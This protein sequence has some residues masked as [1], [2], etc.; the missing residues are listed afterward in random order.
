MKSVHDNGG[1]IGRVNADFAATDS[2][3]SGSQNKKNSGVWSLDAIYLNA[4]LTVSE[5]RYIKWNI[6]N[7]N[8]SSD[9]VQVSDFYIVS[10]GSAVSW[11]SPTVTLTGCAASSPQNAYKLFDSNTSTKFYSY[12]YNTTGRV[13]T[14][15]ADA[16][17]G[18]SYNLDS[19]Y[20]VTGNDS[21]GRDPITWTFE[22]S[23]DGTNY[24]VLDTVTN[25]TITT[26]R[27]ANTQTF[28]L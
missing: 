18:N 24:T 20:Y 28:T 1:F 13:A 16:G 26:S 23:N 3:T 27:L 10:Q 22:A 21:V 11:G 14:I 5:Y 4:Q 7:V 17:A 6:T 12:N 2:Y 25:A 15:V 9:Q 19:Y 8:G